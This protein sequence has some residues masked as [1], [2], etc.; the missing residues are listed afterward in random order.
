MERE[1]TEKEGRS[2]IPKER[3]FPFSFP[4]PPGRNKYNYQPSMTPYETKE[5]PAR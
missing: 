2:R 1:E 4:E 3:G 5:V